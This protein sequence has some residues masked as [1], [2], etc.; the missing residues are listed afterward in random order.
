MVEDLAAG[1][2]R[3]TP[4][5]TAMG[6][7]A[8]LMALS[9][10]PKAAMAAIVSGRNMLGQGGDIIVEAGAVQV[11]VGAGVDPA[12]AR[13]AFSDAGEELASLLTALRRR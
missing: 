11:Q 13:A 5:A 2:S 3:T 10:A 9:M 12:E 6:D 7:I 1:L 8:D 4:V